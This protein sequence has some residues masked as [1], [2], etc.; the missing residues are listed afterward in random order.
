MS[1]LIELLF[2]L[3]FSVPA[4]RMIILAVVPA[5]LLLLYVR[6]KDRLEP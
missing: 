3:I 6:R 1:L 2:G 5:L 4:L